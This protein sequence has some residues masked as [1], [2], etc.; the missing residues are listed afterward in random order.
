M[1]GET[2]SEQEG[3]DHGKDKVF[4]CLFGY[5]FKGVSVA[6]ISVSLSLSLS[7]HANSEA[8]KQQRQENT[9]LIDRLVG[10]TTCPKVAK[11]VSSW[12]SS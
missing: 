6:G 7:I 4:F 9:V 1:K 12:F 3:F 8:I 11:R 5:F 2:P 10:P